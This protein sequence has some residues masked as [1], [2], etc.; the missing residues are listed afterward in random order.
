MADVDD[1]RGVARAQIEHLRRSGV[2]VDEIQRLQADSHG[3]RN[4]HGGGGSEG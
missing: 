4:P 3:L 2:L 1:C